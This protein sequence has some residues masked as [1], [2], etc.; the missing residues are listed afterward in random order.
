MGSI[1]E[2]K[3]ADLVLLNGDPFSSLSR[4]EWT[5]VDGVL[6]FERRDA[7]GLEAEP[8]AS[9]ERVTAF[10]AGS[11]QAVFDRIEAA[12]T[13]GFTSNSVTGSFWFANSA[14]IPEPMIPP[15]TT[16]TRSTFIRPPTA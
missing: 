7:F 15:P 2:G 14:A 16:P 4:V 6:E 3:D 11:E 5:M 1:E 8:P 10:P 12:A 13:S 9:P